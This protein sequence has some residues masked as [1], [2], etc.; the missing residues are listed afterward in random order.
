MIS[1]RGQAV[2]SWFERT[3]LFRVPGYAAVRAIVGGLSSANREGGVKP[4]LM[5]VGDGLV[6]Q[7]PAL[8][9][10]TAAGLLVSKAG[11]SG[12]ADK[13][14]ARQLATM[15]KALGMAAAVTILA[16]AAIGLSMLRKPKHGGNPDVHIDMKMVMRLA[17]LGLL[18]GFAAG[19]F[20]IGGG[21]L[22]AAT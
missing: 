22:M 9:V 8:I 20:G 1:R 12:S 3:L 13:A 4:G 5:T 19:F 10:S 14:I 7:I 2:G 15:P 6:T 16:M 18:T 17:P 21:F 11:V